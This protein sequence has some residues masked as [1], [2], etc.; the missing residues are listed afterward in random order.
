MKPT[1]AAFAIPFVAVAS[2]NANFQ[3]T[4]PAVRGAFSQDSEPQF[5][6]QQLSSWIVQ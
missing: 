4:F 6:G 3:V 2:V 5:C 1:W